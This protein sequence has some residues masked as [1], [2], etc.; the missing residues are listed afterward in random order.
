MPTIVL[1]ISYSFVKDLVRSELIEHSLD[2]PCE[3]VGVLVQFGQ[4]SEEVLICKQAFLET[5]IQELIVSF[6]YV[7]YGPYATISA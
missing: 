4:D 7:V 3:E 5:F 6:H 1:M 2:D